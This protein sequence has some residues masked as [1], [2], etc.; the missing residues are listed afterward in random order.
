[1]QPTKPNKPTEPNKRS[2]VFVRLLIWASFI[3]CCIWVIQ[4]AEYRADI[5][6]FLP[7]NPT[8]NQQLLVD[9]LKEGAISRL[10]LIGIDSENKHSDSKPAHSETLAAISTHMAKAL[11]ADTQWAIVS[12]GEAVGMERDGIY[13][14]NNRY[15][16]SGADSMWTEASLRESLAQSKQWLAQ[17]IGL[18]LKEQIPRDPTGEVLRMIESL[19]NRN[20]ATTEHGVWMGTTQTG[21]ARAVL[22]A[23]TKA[24][25]IDLD[26]QQRAVDAVK[27]AFENAKTHMAKTQPD[28][29]QVKIVLSGTGVF[30]ALSRERIKNDATLFS[31]IATALV[32]ALIGWVYRSPL[33]M[34]VGLLPVVSG[35]LAGITAVALVFDNVHGI[36]LGFGATL[37]GEAVDYA[38]YLFT[39][40]RKDKPNGNS[41]G[42]IKLIW[43]TLRLGVWTSICGFSAMVLSDFPGLQQL[44]VFSVAG[45]VVA[46]LVT[47]WLLP[48][49]LP[50][51]FQIKPTQLGEQFAR[52]ARKAPALRWPL[53]AIFVALI[54]WAAFSQGEFWND[55]LAH[56]SPI[57]LSEQK[58][59]ESL[60]NALGAPDVRLLV[61]AES[62][63]TETTLQS[64]ELAAQTLTALVE[65][66]SVASFDSP[67]TYLP[68]AQSQ[69]QRQAA[70][71]NADELR[72]R[73]DAAI[74]NSGFKP[75]TF[76]PFLTD[77]QAS[78]TMPLVTRA[79]LAGTNLAH[80]V[81]ALLTVKPNRVTAMLPLTGVSDEAKLRHAISDLKS[82]NIRVLDMKIESNALYQSYRYQ[83][84]IYA[85]L[86]VLAIALLLAITL[87]SVRRVV[88]LLIPLAFAVVMT[89]AIL[90]GLGVSLSIFHLV[91][92]L[93]VVGIGSNY[94]LFFDRQVEQD[95]ALAPVMLSLVVCNIS[96]VFGFG[97]LA[98]SSMPVLKAIGG[99]V[100]IGAVLTLIFSAVF[101]QKNKQRQ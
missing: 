25:G 46:V 21:Q 12:N 76:E 43:P 98:L 63:N 47:R 48:F 9:Q 91:A 4:R 7:K 78:K 87:R 66:K 69:R 44:G 55:D 80:Q 89:V 84:M 10:M 36:T 79:S 1:M 27:L 24:A 73:M 86:G 37:I 2:S 29:A 101:V 42:T 19:S 97:V 67:T 81:D 60:R 100:A 38:V 56:L 11:R 49:L 77:A 68:S 95:E 61:V 96:T 14:S 22:M 74:Q 54:A 92:F 3:A 18:F 52:I 16:L 82:P 88:A 93:L 34:G 31:T 70:I 35:V 53:T 51:N 59:D 39:L 5:S 75:N 99:T 17:D 33:V 28:A 94:A 13:L 6:A 8:A 90:L 23:Q 64:A 40:I 71:P 45:L 83:A 15:L 41:H 85:L 30:S 57:S 50:D 62:N 65:A 20:T 32:I 72:K 58:L 26:A